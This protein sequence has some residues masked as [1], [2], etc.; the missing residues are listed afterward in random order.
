MQQVAAPGAL[1]E[2]GAAAA[3]E[4]LVVPRV[5]RWRP[6]PPEVQVCLAPAQQELAVEGQVHAVDDAAV[7][8]PYV[9]DLGEREQPGRWGVGERGGRY[10][11]IAREGGWRTLAERLLV[12]D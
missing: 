12:A 8:L 6:P 11:G 3:L 9:T 4:C 1:R 5:L 7:G 10:P 2:E